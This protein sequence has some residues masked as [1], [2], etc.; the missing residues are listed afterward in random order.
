[1]RLSVLVVAWAL[2]ALALV[3]APAYAAAPLNDLEWVQHPGAPVPMDAPFTAANGAGTTLRQAAGGLPLVLAPGY[4]R[5][6]NLCGVVRQDL[7]DALGRTWLQAGRDYQVAVLSIDP[8]EGPTDAAAVKDA[9]A[10]WRLLTGPAGVVGAAIGFRTRFDEAQ[11]QFIHPAG[12]AVLSPSGLVSGYVLGVGYDPDTLR[13][14]ILLARDGGQATAN[15]VLLLCFHYDPATGRYT[16]A[17]ERLVRI[18][19]TLTALGLG[20][21]LWLTHRPRRLP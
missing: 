15:P 10:G 6:P 7:A 17:V 14:A 12:V 9:G 18:G 19:G 2:V 4:Y 11:R 21:M 20:T 16:L 1:M 3:A 8:A 13:S 5:C